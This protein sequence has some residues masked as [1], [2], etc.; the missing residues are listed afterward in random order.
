VLVEGL[1][2]DCVWRTERVVIEVDSWE[3]HRTRAA[4]E[5]DREKSRILQA[6]GWRC[7]PVTYLQLKHASREVA[8]D[9]RRLLATA[10]L[11]A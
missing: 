6:A 5:R 3:F 9:V 1:E 11:A 2:V 8:R 7:V 10:T 4:F